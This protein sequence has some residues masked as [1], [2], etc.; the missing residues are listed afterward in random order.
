M[1]EMSRDSILGTHTFS[2]L[3][4]HP[5]LRCASWLEARGIVFVAVGDIRGFPESIR[6]DVDLVVSMEDL[7]LL[8]REIFRMGQECG[9]RLVQCFQ[10]E[11]CAFYFVFADRVDPTAPYLR[12]DVCGDYLRNARRLVSA[13]TLLAGAQQDSVNARSSGLPM[14]SHVAGFDYY[15]VKK[16][17]KGSLDDTSFEHLKWLWER[18]AGDL[19]PSCLSSRLGAQSATVVAQ[20]LEE[21]APDRLRG[22]L[23]QLA[24]ELRRRHPRHAKDIRNDIIRRVSRVYNPTGLV[25]AVLGPDGSGKSALLD[26]LETRLLPAFRHVRRMHFRPQLG[27]SSTGGSAQAVPDPH[28]QIPRGWWASLLKLGYYAAAYWGGMVRLFFACKVRSTLV[29]F[30]RYAQDVKVD[31]RRY[32]YGGPPWA[33]RWLGQCVPQPDLVLVLSGEPGVIW[34]RKQETSKEETGRLC[35]AYER[36]AQRNGWQV[37]DA[38]EPL[39]DVVTKA[40]N[41]VLSFLEQRLRRRMGATKAY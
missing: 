19:R 14:P 3:S 7:Q 27:P 4:A 37:L 28:N 17:D 26:G 8:R 21:E 23:P 10:H 16:I 34:H 38:T 24:R 1:K 25:V 39:E 5:L 2:G 33:S 6:G 35:R 36:L 40:E 31:P 32:R 41:V 22:L 30:D 29:L 11:A 15:L 12:L 13:S 20:A 18:L 9:L